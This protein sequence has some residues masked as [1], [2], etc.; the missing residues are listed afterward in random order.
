MKI[1][2]IQPDLVWENPSLNRLN[3]EQKINLIKE[4][5]DLIVLPEMFTTGFTMNPSTVAE[6]MDGKTITWMVSLAKSKN[7]AITGSLIITENG[8]YYNRMIFV[9]PNGKI[10]K[11]DKRH[12]FTLAKE[13]VVF[14]SGQEKVIVEY[15]NWKICLQICYDL[16]FPVFVRNLE[17]YD[18]IIYVASWPEPRVNAWDILLRARAVENLAYVIGVNRV[19][20]DDNQLNYVGHSQIVDYLGNYVISPFEEEVVKII[21]L[22]KKEL[23]E[24]RKRL[25]FLND[26]DSFH[27]F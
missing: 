13:E 9:F 21:A 27:L 22:D 2:I 20:M 10:Q 6:T 19:G 16:R 18:M 23:I 4:K 1:A 7:T 11:Y 25:N 8:K 12:L 3:F 14:T 26:K 24:T 17:D 5:V 15:N